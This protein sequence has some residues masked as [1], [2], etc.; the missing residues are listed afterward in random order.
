MTARDKVVRQSLCALLVLILSG[1]CSDKPNAE[2]LK[3]A[4]AANLQ[5]GI[6]PALMQAAYEGKEPNIKV[7]EIMEIGE[8]KTVETGLFQKTKREVWPV[9]TRVA[10]DAMPSIG[11]M[12]SGKRVDFNVITTFQM[13]QDTSGKWQVAGDFFMLQ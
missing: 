12:R 5:R 1:A 8:A 7:L 11:P 6:H 2:D 13:Y 9:K 10:G 3:A 4:I